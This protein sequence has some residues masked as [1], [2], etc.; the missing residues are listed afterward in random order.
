MTME[1]I[2]RMPKKEKT[3]FLFMKYATHIP[4][5]DMPTSIGKARM[6]ANHKKLTT[7]PAFE[8]P[9]PTDIADM[10]NTK[11]IGTESSAQSTVVAIG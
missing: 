2:G 11:Y 5:I 4:I 6:F 7:P 9:A 8:Q 10:A 3:F 1:S